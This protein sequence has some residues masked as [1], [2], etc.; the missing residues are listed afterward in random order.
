MSSGGREAGYGLQGSKWRLLRV[1]HSLPAGG[2]IHSPPSPRGP[3][4]RASGPRGLVMP[5]LTEAWRPVRQGPVMSEWEGSHRKNRRV[6]SILLACQDA[7]M[8]MSDRAKLFCHS[9]LWGEFIRDSASMRT[10]ADLFRH[11]RCQEHGPARSP[12]LYGWAARRHCRRQ[13]PSTYAS[14]PRDD[15]R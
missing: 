6:R 9:L 5:W 12:L 3:R 10:S 1:N 13:R 7:K 14:H 8:G 2:G 4:G 15:A 11:F